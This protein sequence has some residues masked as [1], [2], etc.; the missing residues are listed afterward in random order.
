MLHHSQSGHRS[1]CMAAA[2]LLEKIQTNLHGVVDF[3]DIGYI[4]LFVLFVVLGQLCFYN[5]IHTIQNL[6]LCS[7]K[8]KHARFI[9]DI[10]ISSLP[11]VD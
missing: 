4:H 5:H 3:F 9:D 11:L 1:A 7:V 10:Q 6:Y 2:K 8:V